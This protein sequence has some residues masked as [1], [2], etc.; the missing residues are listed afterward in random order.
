MSFSIENEFT[1]LLTS[2][3]SKLDDKVTDIVVSMTAEADIDAYSVLKAGATANTV[4][5]MLL[6]DVAQTGVVGVSKAAALAGQQVDVVVSGLFSVS[7]EESQAVAIGEQLLKSG[8]DTGRVNSVSSASLAAGRFG[9]ALSAGT[10][11]ASGDVTVLAL[12][13]NGTST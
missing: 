9:V 1:T 12:F 2:L 4:T 10:G 11:S 7:V 3:N 8:V 5:M 13:R 6:G